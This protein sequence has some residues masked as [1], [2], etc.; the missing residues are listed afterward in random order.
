M[1]SVAAGCI[2]SLTDFFLLRDSEFSFERVCTDT[3]YRKRL[4]FLGDAVLKPYVVK[5]LVA[6]QGLQWID[7][8]RQ[9]EHL[10][11]NAYLSVVFEKLKL[12]KSIDSYVGQWGT[13]DIHDKATYVEAMLGLTEMLAPKNSCTVVANIISLLNEMLPEPLPLRLPPFE[14]RLPKSAINKKPCRLS[15]AG[16]D[17]LSSR[18]ASKPPTADQKEEATSKSRSTMLAFSL[19]TGSSSEIRKMH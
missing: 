1:A 11:S 17:T 14:I 15:C 10:V 7:L 8:C 19:K 12:Q 9:T 4:A 6:R 5:F 13:N 16:A 3:P 2:A 18:A